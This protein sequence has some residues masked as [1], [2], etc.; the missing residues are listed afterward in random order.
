MFD[1]IHR[2]IREKRIARNLTK[3]ASFRRFPGRASCRGTDSKN[4][5]ASEHGDH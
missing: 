3:T 5:P 4:Q 2:L 1:N